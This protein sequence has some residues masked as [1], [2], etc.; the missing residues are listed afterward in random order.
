MILHVEV[1]AVTGC[2]QTKLV[3]VERLI[4]NLSITPTQNF[5]KGNGFCTSALC[6]YN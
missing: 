1:E 4:F 2:D 6:H 3:K 5:E